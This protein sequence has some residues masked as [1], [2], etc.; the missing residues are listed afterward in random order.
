MQD[1]MVDI[2]C[3]STQLGAVILTIGAVA[4]DPHSDR[5]GPT[6]SVRLPTQEQIEKGALVDTDT[7]DWWINQSP[8]ARNAAFH[9][10]GASSVAAGLAKFSRFS[11]HVGKENLRLWS[12]GPAFDSAQLQLT[13]ARFKAELGNG[14]GWPF[15]Y[16]ADRDCRTI[17]ELAYPDEKVPVETAGTAHNALDDALWQA[18]AVQVCMRKLRGVH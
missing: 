2:E 10:P 1:I 3:L 9:G 16:N 5:I 15:R 13:Y 4:F 18:K 11:S 6:F 8:E 12:N 7:I 14:Q 17:F